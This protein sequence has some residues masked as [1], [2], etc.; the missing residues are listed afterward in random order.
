MSTV[1]TC[2]IWCH[3]DNSMGFLNTT[4]RAQE[5]TLFPRT[6]LS[7]VQVIVVRPVDR[8]SQRQFFDSCCGNAKAS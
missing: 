5:F 6:G 4:H 8:P 1:I 7:T 3:V 2:V